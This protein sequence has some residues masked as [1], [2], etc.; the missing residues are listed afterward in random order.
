MSSSS[1]AHRRA[2]Q[3]S[4][5]RKKTSRSNG[6]DDEYEESDVIEL[7]EEGPPPIDCIE[8]LPMAY[9]ERLQVPLTQITAQQ[10]FPASLWQHAPIGWF[11]QKKRKGFAFRLPNC[12]ITLPGLSESLMQAFW[13]DYDYTKVN[14][15]IKKKQEEA[16]KHGI[17][18]AAKKS[19]KLMKQNFGTNL[20]V[21][22]AGTGKTKGFERGTLVDK[23]L[24]W[25]M[26]RE[27]DES[28]LGD[29]FYEVLPQEEE[30]WRQ[31]PWQLPLSTVQRLH[32]QARI[33][34]LHMSKHLQ[35]IPLAAQVPAW[36][37]FLGVG[38]FVE[39]LWYDQESKQ[40]ILVEFKIAQDRFLHESHAPLKHP[41][42]HVSNS[43]LHRYMLQLYFQKFMYE[44][45]Y[46]SKI[47]RSVLVTVDEYLKLTLYS[48]TG[49]HESAGWN[50]IYPH[51][52]QAVQA[53]RTEH[54]IRMAYEKQEEVSNTNEEEEEEGDPLGEERKQ[55]EEE[56]DENEET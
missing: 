17:V 54:A 23:Q 50:W 43:L 14:Q 13:P 38:T 25:V 48:L 51:H 36:H 19:F 1:A 39:H 35:C 10:A 41:F 9:V 15:V 6:T 3:S 21:Y 49:T 2:V 33:Y 32:P 24:T 12:S 27:Q 16:R 52:I 56:E 20:Q 53:L 7:E 26:N 4:R 30:D 40:L 18:D 44:Q 45:T 28:L 22:C 55:N 34:L 42:S 37:K 47:H 31:P 46:A 8:N 29:K 11:R 5:K